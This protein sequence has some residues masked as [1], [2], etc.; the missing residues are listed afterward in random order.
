MRVPA[1][2]SVLI[3]A[4]W[5]MVAAFQSAAAGVSTGSAFRATYAQVSDIEVLTA[6]TSADAANGRYAVEVSALAQA[7]KLASAGFAGAP[8]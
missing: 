6:S 8:T 1:P 3:L 2:R 4:K 5:A 7:Q